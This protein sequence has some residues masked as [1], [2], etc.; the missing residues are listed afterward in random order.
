MKKEKRAQRRKLSK[1][2]YKQL[3]DDL[4]LLGEDLGTP[5]KLL[6]T[7]DKVADFC[8]DVFTGRIK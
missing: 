7:I 6:K 4:M 3:F 5:E 2:F 1:T 8:G